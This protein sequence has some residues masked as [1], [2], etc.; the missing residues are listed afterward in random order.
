MWFLLF[1]LEYTGY[2]EAATPRVVAA[3]LAFPALT[4]LLVWTNPAHGLIWTGRRVIVVDG[5]ALM[6]ESYG[7]WFW[8]YLAY[9]Y[10][11]TLLAAALIVRL[12][13]ISDSLFAD[14]AGL[15]LVGTVVPLTATVASVLSIQPLPGLDMGPYALVVTGVTWG[16]AL[17]R[18]KL[19]DLVPAAHR[20]GRDAAIRDLEDGVL[21]VDNSQQVIYCNSAA[22]DLLDSTPADMLGEP[23]RSL[24]DDSALD[25]D[26]EDAL[27]ELERDDA[28]F[29]IRTSP[30]RDRSDR[31]IGHT[32]IVQE[33]TARKRREQRVA[34]QRD[35]LERLEALNAVI[36]GVNRALVSATSREEVERAV[37]DRLTESERFRTAYVADLPTWNGDASRWTVA[38]E[39]EAGPSLPDALRN[40]GVTIADSPERPVPTSVP[41]DPERKR[42]TV[43]PLVYGRTVYG[44]LGLCTRRTEDA[45]GPTVTD[46]EREVLAELGE[47]IGHA[48][49]AV[50]NRRLLAAESVVELDVRSRDEDGPLLATAVRTGCTLAVSGLV[51]NA[52]DGHLAYLHVT[53]GDAETAVDALESASGTRVRSIRPGEGDETPLVEWQVPPDALIGTLLEQGAHVLRASTDD[54]TAQFRVEM[55]GDADVRALADRIQQTYPE[56]RIEAK[57]ELSR[58]ADRGDAVLE[59]TIEDLTDRQQEAMEAAYRAG[60]FS[61]PRDSTAEDVA[62]GLDISAPTL[63][64]HL[65][66]AEE[67]LLADLFDDRPTRGE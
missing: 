20:L 14:Q 22:T 36:R 55:A 63:H 45:D 17:F 34:R 54:D 47:L 50:E 32:V 7:P 16:Y 6:S 43:V 57:R 53:E 41:D 35:E 9:G 21:I 3:L 23:A 18:R 38:G 27:A 29:E 33:I 56:T 4:L 44:A 25:F 58:P 66:K 24:V 19:F 64:A 65:R 62:D 28:V 11:L 26:T 1:A 15:L 8:A 42:W 37:C 61:W 60:Y 40:D 39:P 46:R 48:I 52:G 51:P 59:D 5:L 31:L 49:D 67:T 10:G 2:D 13:F 12:V 30:I